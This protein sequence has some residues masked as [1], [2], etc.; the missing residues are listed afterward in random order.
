MGYTTTFQGQFDLDRPLAPE[1]KNYLKAFSEVRHMTWNAELL[2]QM[3]DDPIRK[4]V[5]LP[6][7][8]DGRYFTG[9]VA[10]RGHCVEHP[11]LASLTLAVGV[12]PYPLAGYNFAPPE[13]TKPLVP[14]GTQS[15]RNGASMG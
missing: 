4:A 5:G 7:G 9:S 3:E 11:A 10:L 12:P 14:V 13:N 15:R 1:H 2:E 8:E 6:I